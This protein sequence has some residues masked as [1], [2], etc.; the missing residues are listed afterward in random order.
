LVSGVIVTDGRMISRIDL[1]AV[2]PREIS[3][4]AA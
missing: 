2:F 1:D 3:A 4:E